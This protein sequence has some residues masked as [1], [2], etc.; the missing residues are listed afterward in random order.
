MTPKQLSVSLPW[1]LSHYIPLNGFHPLYRALIDHAPNSII[2]NAWDNVKLQSRLEQDHRFR[3]QL[4]TDMQTSPKGHVSSKRE[5]AQQH[6]D[7]YFWLPD[8]RL[9]SVLPGDIEF[10]HTSPFPSFTRP[11]VFHCESFMPIFFPFLQQEPSLDIFEEPV[12]KFYLDLFAHPLCLGIFSHIPETLENFRQ[13]FS[14]KLIN[15]KLFHSA[16]GLSQTGSKKIKF[17]NKPS[18]AT[19]KFLFT[20]ST[21]QAPSSFFLRG[22][23]IILKFW[24]EFI[25]QQRVGQLILRCIKP[26]DQELSKHNVDLSFIRDQEGKSILWIQDYLS[27]SEQRALMTS[28]NFF[29]LPSYTLHSASILEAMNSGTIPIVTDTVGTSVYIQDNENGVILTGVRSALWHTNPNTNLL[30]EQGK[31][32]SELEHTMVNQLTK[33]IFALLDNAASYKR[34]QNNTIKHASRHFSGTQFANIFWSKVNDLYQQYCSNTVLANVGAT[35]SIDYSNCLIQQDWARIFDSATQPL[36]R[37][38]TGKNYVVELGGTYIHIS[39]PRHHTQLPL[40]ALSVVSPYY[41]PSTCF[42]IQFA[43][44]IHDLGA[45]YLNTTHPNPAE[46][47][48]IERTQSKARRYFS[49]LLMPYPRIHNFAAMVNKK[50]RD[51]T[52]RNSAHPNITLILE[53]RYGYNIIK[54]KSK[55]YAILQKDGKFSQIEFV[56]GKYSSSYSSYFLMII[57]MRI[58]LIEI[59]STLYNFAVYIYKNYIILKKD[60]SVEMELLFQG[61]AGYNI[62][63]YR[64]RYYTISQSDGL[65]SLDAFKQSHYTLSYSSHSLI[66][67]FIF[68]GLTYL[69]KMISR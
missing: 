32:T 36:I 2:F 6:Y 1:S 60:P 69:K 22:G 10:H 58:G 18:L 56:K 9:T 33:K 62:I 57:Y 30:L 16:I 55:Y 63:R 42:P 38:C 7:D 25:G 39:H 46:A 45:L 51:L 59:K 67:I 66:S 26:T 53:G 68:I 40:Q 48:I 8:Q 35:K 3:E 27:I 15:E 29:L 50:L 28:A 31:V 13:Y 43:Y 24:Q 17:S 23:H 11:F 12:K 14:S 61:I 41:N 21:Y 64:Y 54:C 34:I 52:W 44:R 4:L 20:N 37:L 47:Y 5:L 49:N 65:F 19:P